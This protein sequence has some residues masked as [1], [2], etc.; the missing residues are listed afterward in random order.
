MMVLIYLL[1]CVV[2]I[3][4]LVGFL[5]YKKV[6]QYKSA[7]PE[8][9]RVKNIQARYTQLTDNLNQAV[10][11]SSSELSLLNALKA[12]DYPTETLRVSWVKK[13]LDLKN[14]VAVVEYEEP[15]RLSVNSSLRLTHNG[16][17]YGHN[18]GQHF[19]I[20]EHKVAK[21]GKGHIEIWLETDAPIQPIESIRASI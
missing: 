14:G 20:L 10:E 19:L 4:S 5:I 8:E 9:A 2:T 16:G 3:T 12:I 6:K 11:T 15:P 17:G 7:M 1:I 18:N 13:G 21:H